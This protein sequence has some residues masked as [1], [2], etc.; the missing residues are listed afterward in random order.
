MYAVMQVEAE[1]PLDLNKVIVVR[2]ARLIMWLGFID[3]IL[4]FI[5]LVGGPVFLVL[6]IFVILAISG[7]LAGKLVSRPWAYVYL[8][9]LFCLII[10]RVILMILFLSV[11]VVILILLLICIDI[12]ISVMVIRYIKLLNTITPDERVELRKWV[13]FSC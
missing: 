13:T 7:Y 8:I 11:I 10:T 5:M 12:Y 1:S 6:L 4:I 3:F 9:S 2:Y